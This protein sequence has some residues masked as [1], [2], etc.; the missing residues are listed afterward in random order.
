MS[1]SSFQ[2]TKMRVKP[3]VRSFDQPFVEPLFRNAG[4]IASDKQNR[5]S[6]R[7]ESEG[8]TSDAVRSVEPQFLHIGMLRVLQCIRV[9]SA[10]MRAKLGKQG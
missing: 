9:G 1:F 5:R 4:F 8:N 2:G 3:L 7:V 6:N 10:Q